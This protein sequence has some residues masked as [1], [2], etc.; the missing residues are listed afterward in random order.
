MFFSKLFGRSHDS[1]PSH[2]TG[3]DDLRKE[4]DAGACALIDVREP[5]EFAQGHVP[6]SRNMPLSRFNVNMLPRD[7]KVVLICR[8]GARSGSALRAARAAGLSEVTH[9]SGGIALWHSLGGRVA[10]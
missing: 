7:R 2:V 9:F 3:F 5:G 6:G 1:G 8:S 4:L 10:R